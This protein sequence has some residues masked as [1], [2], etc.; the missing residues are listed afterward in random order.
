MAGTP[1]SRRSRK[2]N[3]QA[4]D[5]P[6]GC[7]AIR[8]ICSPTTSES[9]RRFSRNFR[10]GERSSRRRMDKANAKSSK[11]HTGSALLFRAT[12]LELHRGCSPPLVKMMQRAAAGADLEPVG[13]GDG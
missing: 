7:P 12:S 13:G 1:A 8:P 5:Q 9:R 2:L 4:I 6:S 3:Y 11:T 10:K